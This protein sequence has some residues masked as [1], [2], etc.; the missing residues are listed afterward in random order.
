MTHLHFNASSAFAFSGCAALLGVCACFSSPALAGEPCYT[1]STEI[2]IPG[3]RHFGGDTS[4]VWDLIVFDDGTG[5]ALYAGGQFSRAGNINAVHNVAKWE[6]GSTW[7]RLDEGLE[8]DF[9]GLHDPMVCAMEV[10]DDGTGPALY[11][12]GRFN[13]AGGEPADNI[14]KWDGEAWTEVGGGLADPVIDWVAAWSDML[15]WDDGTGSALYVASNY[16][17]YGGQA[18]GGIAKWDGKSWTELDGGVDG[19][20]FTLGV[21]DDG[22]GEALYA[23]GVFTTAGGA[24]AY[25]IAKWDGE[26]WSALPE[27][28]DGI[29]NAT[30]DRP[31]TM[32]TWDDGTGE[33]LYIGGDYFSDQSQTRS[34]LTWDGT[35]WG[36]I[37]GAGPEIHG[38]GIFDDGSGEALYAGGHINFVGGEHAVGKWDGTQWTP[39]G[40]F[41][42]PASVKTLL[43]LDAGVVTA[44][45]SVVVAGG[46]ETLDGETVRR[47]AIF[48]PCVDELC[49]AD[50]VDSKTFQPPGDGIVDAADLAYLLGEWGA[51]PGSLADIVDSGTFQPPPDG[52]VNAADLAYLLGAWGSCE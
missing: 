28:P 20:I 39:I 21:Y 16:A 7:S 41:P 27:A 22:N 18:V 15:I 11:V 10:F 45:A 3:I 38:L 19:S 50:S 34:L 40:G 33:K 8:C 4:Y 32:I 25:N 52:V 23:G 42:N 17:T 29:L 37:T 35:E 12:L 48:E 13:E 9:C 49:I 30:S 47:I 51:N 24:P 43:P 36:V 2:G 26:Q 1:W 6:G 5:P 14:A 46:F 44:G 31:H